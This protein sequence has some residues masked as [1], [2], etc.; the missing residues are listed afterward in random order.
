MNFSVSKE[1]TGTLK[2]G[3][4]GQVEIPTGE[5]WAEEEWTGGAEKEGDRNHNEGAAAA[6]DVREWA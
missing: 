4:K 1:T 3:S 5:E 6:E 2:A